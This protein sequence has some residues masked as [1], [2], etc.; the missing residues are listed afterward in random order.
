MIFEHEMKLLALYDTVVKYNLRTEALG[1]LG[2]SIKLFQHSPS[3]HQVVAKKV[4]TELDR[5]LAQLDY[6]KKELKT[7]KSLDIKEYKAE[8]V[9]LEKDIDLYT[10]QRIFVIKQLDKLKTLV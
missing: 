10:E 2:Q 5:V 7:D 1:T 6:Y 8:L 4:L 9:L 3:Q